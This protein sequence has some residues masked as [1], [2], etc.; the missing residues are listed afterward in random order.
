MILYLLQGNKNFMLPRVSRM[1]RQDAKSAGIQRGTSIT[2]LFQ[3]KEKCMMQFAQNVAKTQK[4]LSN[5]IW[6]NLCIAAN[7]FLIAKI[8]NI[9]VDNIFDLHNSNSLCL[10]F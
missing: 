10:S 8:I 2:S 6:K 5:H 7:A 4:F 9:F 3:Q 1:N